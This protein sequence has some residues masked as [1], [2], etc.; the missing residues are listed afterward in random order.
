[1]KYQ[2]ALGLKRCAVASAVAGGLFLGGGIIAPALAAT[3]TPTGTIM[4][5]APSAEDLKFE[6]ELVYGVESKNIKLDYQFADPDG[7]DESGSVFSWHVIDNGSGAESLLDNQAAIL[8]FLPQSAINNALRACVT[9]KTNAVTT[10]PSQGAEVCT[11]TTVLPPPPLIEQVDFSVKEGSGLFIDTNN[12][13][14]TYVYKG[15]GNDSSIYAYGAIGQSQ[16]LLEN[17]KGA[18]TNAGVIPDFLMTGYA[19]RKIELSIQPQSHYGGIGKVVTKVLDAYI[20]N[21]NLP[22]SIK[23]ASYPSQG[24]GKFSEF[25]YDFDQAGGAEGDKST[26]EFYIGNTLINSGDA[27][28]GKVPQQTIPQGAYGNGSYKLTPRNGSGISGEKYEVSGFPQQYVQNTSERPVISGLTMTAYTTYTVGQKLKGSYIFHDSMNRS[29]SSRFIWREFKADSQEEKRA[30]INSYWHYVDIGSRVY[31]YII[32]S[33]MIGKKVE[34]LVVGRPTSSSVESA[35]VASVVS[36]VV[37]GGTQPL[38]DAEK[39]PTIERASVLPESSAAYYQYGEGRI[40]YQFNP[41][42]GA[43]E[44]NS[45]VYFES[46]NIFTGKKTSRGSVLQKNKNGLFRPPC[47][48][49]EKLTM[50]LVP[51]NELGVEGEAVTV[52]MADLKKGPSGLGYCYNTQ[53][54]LSIANPEITF[55]SPDKLLYVGRELNATYS[56][57]NLSP[58]M[59]D[60]SRVSWNDEPEIAVTTHGVVPTYILKDKDIGKPVKLTI[61]YREGETTDKIFSITKIVNYS[62]DSFLSGIVLKPEE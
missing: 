12:L 24:G 19:G 7:D 56:G 18:E 33:S 37:I 41:N 43:L 13:V 31:D 20:Y 52:T 10:T 49:N 44:D 61:K 45:V 3:S 27:V 9:P 39:K 53:A 25:S 46:E 62:T 11:T 22:P 38:I 6:P 1:M 35:E 26:F 17:G 51:K 16:M 32:P 8:P 47:A 58:G 50:T 23:S 48:I 30:F 40:S 57:F 14:A 42:G 28:N 15:V 54:L 5:R 36:P 55:S 59:F 21:P 29:D 34:L 2:W 4:G 60:V